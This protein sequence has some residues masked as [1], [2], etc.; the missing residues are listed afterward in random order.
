[1]RR[2]FHRWYSANLGRDMELL[3]FGHAG[4]RVLIFPTSVGRFHDW[5]DR[6]MIAHLGGQIDAGNIQVF[7]VDSVDRE[8]WY[9]Y[10]KAP[11]ERASRHEQYDRYLLHEVIP[12]IESE[13]RTPF[14]IAVGG[15]F[16]GYHAIN[17]AL[18]HPERVQRLLS[19][20]GLADIRRFVGDFYDQTV[21]LNNPV[22]FVANEH[23]PARLEALR[24]LDIILAVGRDDGLRESNERLAG[25]LWNKGIGNALRIWDGFAHDWPVWKQML[26]RYLGGHD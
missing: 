4:A 19:L 21:Y 11:W 26:D 5:E 7:C 6:G 2:V 22:D 24:R 8:S 16:G 3:A 15:S 13:N 25:R 17:F 18:K 9:A 1:M 23:D 12:Y 20:S 10:H 14:L